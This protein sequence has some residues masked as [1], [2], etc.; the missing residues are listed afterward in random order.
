MKQKNP[1][2]TKNKTSSF[3]LITAQENETLY[4]TEIKGGRR[5]KDKCIDQG[6]VPGRKI[7]IL[8]NSG[9]GPCLVKLFN[10]RIMIGRGMLNRIYV[11]T[12]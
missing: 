5:F 10:T 3:P 6:L 9:N 4:I 11:R 1:M 7:E 8:N 12:V 2:E